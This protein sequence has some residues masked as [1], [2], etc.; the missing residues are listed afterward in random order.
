M[1]SRFGPDFSPKVSHDGKK[2]A[3]LGFNDKFLGYQQ[4][5]LYV[6]DTDGQ[7]VKNISKDFDRNITS[8]FWSGDSKKIF[9]KYVFN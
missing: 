2:I 1:T 7:N 9:F 6:M 5:D 4:N 8:I 3:F